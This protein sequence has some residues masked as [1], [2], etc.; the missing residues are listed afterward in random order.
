MSAGA[1]AAPRAV[2]RGHLSFGRLLLF[3]GLAIAAILIVAV[4]LVLTRTPPAPTPDCTTGEQCG[5]PPPGKPLVNG[6]IWAGSAIPYHFEYDQSLWEVADEDADGVT[7]QVSRAGVWVVVS[8]AESSDE[9]PST[10]FNNAVSDL[11]GQLA[12]APD[13][14]P[15]HAI[16]GAKVGDFH[17][18][19]VG[20]FAGST[21][22][23]QGGVIPVRAIIMSA[24]DGQATITVTLVSPEDNLA[25]A[26]QEVDGLLN[27]LR[28]PSE[29][30]V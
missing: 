12:L 15:D 8:A 16:L 5:N 19:A 4:V 28:Y 11:S 27:T 14:D 26:S 6:Q 17:A 24:T 29:L 23:G 1:A 3:I 9:D 21:N 7:L 25:P 13:T 22:P 30:D 18:D 20:V 10:A 2:R